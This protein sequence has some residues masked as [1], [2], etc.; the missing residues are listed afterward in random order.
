MR[1]RIGNKVGENGYK[2][3]RCTCLKDDTEH[4]TRVFTWNT[5]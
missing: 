1:I 4:N 5:S 3:K 2:A